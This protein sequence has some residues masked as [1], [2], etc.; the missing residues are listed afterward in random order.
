MYKGHQWLL[1][2]HVPTNHFGVLLKMKIAGSYSDSGSD[3]LTQGS[4]VYIFNK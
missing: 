1:N 2:F 4:R 3:S